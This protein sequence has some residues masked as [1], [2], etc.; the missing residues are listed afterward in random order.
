MLKKGRRLGITLTS[1]ASASRLDRAAYSR[2]SR[3][4]AVAIDLHAASRLAALLAVLSVL[5]SGPGL[6]PACASARAQDLEPADR[7]CPAAHLIANQGAGRAHAS[8]RVTMADSVSGL[9]WLLP[10]QKIWEQ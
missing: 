10:R 2:A 5:L 6:R 7:G 4:M 3:L 9:S 8:R 1:A